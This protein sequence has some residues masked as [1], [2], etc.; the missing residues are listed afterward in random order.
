M[1]ITNN[2]LYSKT[3][4]CEICVTYAGMLVKYLTTFACCL[5]VT[6]DDEEHSENVIIGN[7]LR[8]LPPKI[9][10]SSFQSQ[11]LTH[12]TKTCFDKLL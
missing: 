12:N 8:L 4:Y 1:I 11:Q 2:W 7:D 10:I 5:S 3:N 9:C 6:E